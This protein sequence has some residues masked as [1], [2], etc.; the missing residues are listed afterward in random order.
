MYRSLPSSSRRAVLRMATAGVVTSTLPWPAAAADASPQ[1]RALA[2][3]DAA[4]D[5]Y[6][7]QGSVRLAQS[8]TDQAG[9]FSTAFTYD[10]ALAILAYLAHGRTERAVLL[11]DGLLFAQTRDPQYRD[12]RLR[13]VYN[14]GPYTFYDGVPQ[15]DGLVRADGQANVGY[16]F[17]FLGTAVGDMAWAGL[18]LAGLARRTGAARF[19]TG[20]LN[21]GNWI[22]ANASTT[23][24][25][26][27]P[28]GGFKG[29]VDGANQRLV[30]SATEHNIDLIGL[31]GQLAALTG[32]SAWQ[33]QRDRAV[34]FVSAM[35]D[36]ASGFFYTGT[37]DGVSI[38]RYPV[39]EDTQ[40]WTYLALRDRR[41]AGALDWAAARL[42]VVDSAD[43]TNSTV[44]PG[45]RF[46]GVTFS[47]A[48][49][50]ANE[51][52]PIAAYQPRPNRSGV[53]FEGS[54]H[55]AAALRQRRDAGDEARASQLLTSIEQAQDLLG[56]G[57]TLGGIVLP[58][59]T[60]VVA[61][62]SPLDTGY[63]FG[64]YPYRHVGA[65]AWYLLAAASANPWA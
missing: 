41:Y 60:G 52:A 17:G 65:S 55:L 10:N 5:A 38:N 54:A 50:L 8:Y 22:V 61:A 1:G 3:L 12:G 36:T 9:L 15:R 25:T 58:A 11:G 21:I 64:Y 43:R 63:G 53:W 59:R 33:G 16:Q 24:P 49:L 14:V 31:F 23:P 6:P 37:N 56:A 27:Q 32:N 2:F 39:P 26:S 48:G 18:A 19:L 4:M 30:Y 44:P 29:G 40:T 46:E 42:A 34:A 13:Q 35:W 51:S 20:A 62:S 28:L 47:S 45:T 7:A 57:Q